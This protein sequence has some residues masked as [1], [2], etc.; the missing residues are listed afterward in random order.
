MEI[1]F[2]QFGS[3]LGYFQCLLQWFEVC[4]DGIEAYDDDGD[5]VFSFFVIYVY[6]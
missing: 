2:F 1:W 4:F 3:S 5:G 6:L